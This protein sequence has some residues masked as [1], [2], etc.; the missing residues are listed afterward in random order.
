MRKKFSVSPFPNLPAVNTLFYPKEKTR[1]KESTSSVAPR[2]PKGSGISALRL[3]A[4]SRPLF[5]A[6]ATIM[7][8]SFGCLSLDSTNRGH[9]L[10]CTFGLGFWGKTISRLYPESAITFYPICKSRIIKS[11]WLIDLYF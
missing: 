2:K 1:K 5:I 7:P 4:V 9:Y 11:D 10:R 3:V 6:M 8:N